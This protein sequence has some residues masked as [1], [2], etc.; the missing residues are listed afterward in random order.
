MGRLASLLLALA[1]AVPAAAAHA[2]GVPPSNGRIAF[3]TISGI[4]SINPDGSGS[5]ALRYTGIGQAAP[6]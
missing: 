3:S 2:A 5:W 4:A 6:A 1:T